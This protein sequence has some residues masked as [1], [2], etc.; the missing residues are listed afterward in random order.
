MGLGLYFHP[1]AKMLYIENKSLNQRIQFLIDIEKN[2][3]KIN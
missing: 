2:I 1:L 3:F